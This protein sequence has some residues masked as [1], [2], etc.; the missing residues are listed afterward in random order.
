M[1]FSENTFFSIFYCQLN[2]NLNAFPVS[3]QYSLILYYVII[4]AFYFH[5]ILCLVTFHSYP[6]IPYTVFLFVL[7]I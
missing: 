4:G 3:L 2:F 5:C 6:I 7:F 1:G